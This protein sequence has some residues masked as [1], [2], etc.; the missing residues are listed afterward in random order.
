[1]KATG[2]SSPRSGSLIR[3]SVLL[4]LA[5][6]AAAPPLS[7]AAAAEVS[8][9]P[10]TGVAFAQTRSAPGAAAPLEL[11]GVGVRTKLFFKVYAFGLYVDPE[12]A[13]AAL[14]RW[15]GHPAG[16]LAAD[17]GLRQALVELPGDRVALLHFVMSVSDRKM[18]E[19]MTEAMDRGLPADDPA[20][21][22]FLALWNAPIE[23]HEEVLLHFSGDGTVVLI[24]RGVSLGAVKSPLLARC[25]LQS[26]LG[27][28]PVSEDIRRGVVSRI[29]LILGGS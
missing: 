26:W 22:A 17:A 4:A 3:L 13:R 9:E 20:R 7:S 29:P 2:R 27:P 15:T 14:Q 24:R 10:A 11:T 12:A 28:D 16:S 25:L 21:A 19:A 6:L 1:M 23:K 18:R 5:A 8:V